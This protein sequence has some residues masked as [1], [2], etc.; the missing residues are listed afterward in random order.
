MNDPFKTSLAVVGRVLLALIFI[1][2]G[3]GKLGNLDGT[4]GYIASVGLPAGGALALA[5]GLLEL[6]AGIALVVGFKARWAALALGVFTLVAALLFHRY[7]AMPAEQQFMQQLLFM[8]NLAIAGGLF[9]VASL[10]AGAAS[11]DRRAVR[12]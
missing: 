3:F 2:S 5:A 8:K 10:G 9:L 12:A 1:T 4:A 7:W 6:V 11:F